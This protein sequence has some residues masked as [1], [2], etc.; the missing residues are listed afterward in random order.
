M[1]EILFLGQAALENLEAAEKRQEAL[2]VV[3]QILQVV[4]ILPVVLPVVLPFR[5]QA[6]LRQESQQVGSPQ[7]RLAAPALQHL[8]PVLP[9]LLVTLSRPVC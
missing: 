2:Q 7:T 5:N 4:E 8:L 6:A 9:V 3:R 1:V